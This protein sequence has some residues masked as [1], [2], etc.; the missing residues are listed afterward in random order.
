MAKRH[1]SPLATQPQ[2]V[3]P[4]LT[5]YS[6]AVLQTD[7]DYLTAWIAACQRDELEGEKEAAE[8]PED[9][10]SEPAGEP[11]D[12]TDFDCAFEDDDAIDTNLP[13]PLSTPPSTPV[14][15]AQP[16]SLGD[17][18]DELGFANIITPTL[19]D[20]VACSN[21]SSSP[22]RNTR[23]ASP[24]NPTSSPAPPFRTD[25]CTAFDD[26]TKKRK[27]NDAALKADL[28]SDDHKK[29]K[30]VEDLEKRSME[31][32]PVHGEEFVQ[33]DL[34]PDIITRDYDVLHFK[35]VKGG[36]TGKT[37]RKAGRKKGPLSLDEAREKNY[38]YF[39]WKGE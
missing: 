34:R 11:V 9:I 28:A 20:N 7:F 21:L 33:R 32:M 35:A 5:T 4:G 23:T 10:R 22:H 30:T 29:R 39:P 1:L 24:S 18:D 31:G 19:Q 27:R 17:A 25:A 37:E 12:L 14:L 26:Q 16:D 8:N 36:D 6:P 15:S 13:S 38:G 3:S 2:A